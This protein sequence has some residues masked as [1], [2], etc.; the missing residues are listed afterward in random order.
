M[1]IM[2]IAVIFTHRHYD[3]TVIDVMTGA[4]SMY[5]KTFVHSISASFLAY[6]Q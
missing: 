6:F 1:I 2:N 5:V 3:N 4:C